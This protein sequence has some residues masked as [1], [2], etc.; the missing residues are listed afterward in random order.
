LRAG[1]EAQMTAMCASTANQ[2]HAGYDSQVMS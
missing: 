1:A 2:I